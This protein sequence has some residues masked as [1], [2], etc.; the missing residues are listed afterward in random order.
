MFQAKN[1]FRCKEISKDKLTVAEYKVDDVVFL[2]VRMIYRKQFQQS[3]ECFIVLEVKLEEYGEK[4]YKLGNMRGVLDGYVSAN[5]MRLCQTND[6]LF[7][8]LNEVWELWVQKR[9]P[10]LSEPGKLLTAIQKQAKRKRDMVTEESKW[11]I[12]Y[13]RSTINRIRSA[14]CGLKGNVPFHGLR[15]FLDRNF[16]NDEEEVLNFFFNLNQE[17][18]ENSIAFKICNVT[19]VQRSLKRLTPLHRLNV[20]TFKSSWIDDSVI[21]G[22]LNL[23]AQST[24][25]PNFHVV[26]PLFF[27]E[28]EVGTNFFLRTSTLDRK[29]KG[30]FP[31]D[32]LFFLVHADNVHWS[33]V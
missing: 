8:S 15:Q 30:I 7:S 19:I 28:Y 14:W 13:P 5:K 25:N 3:T 26:D 21:K 1:F 9:L 24:K 23:L 32:K 4:R 2:S 12:G 17:I 18:D 33:V 10:S 27:Q 16:S 11:L 6:I 20:S 31:F 22:Y 29:E